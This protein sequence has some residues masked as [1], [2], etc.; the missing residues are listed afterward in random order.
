M[1]IHTCDPHF[2]L[3]VSVRVF[4][5]VWMSDE[6][7]LWIWMTPYYRLMYSLNTKGQRKEIWAQKF[8]S[9]LFWL[10]TEC[11][12]TVYV[13]LSTN[14]SLPLLLPYHDGQNFQMRGW[15]TPFHLWIALV[16]YF[17]KGTRK[18]Y[19]KS[20]KRFVTKLLLIIPL[21]ESVILS[22][23]FQTLVLAL[24]NR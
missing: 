23:L 12:H 10:G 16:R 18:I 9:L 22:L 20:I 7:H 13:P 21:N 15:K 6:D 17:V 2:I 8:I 19:N 3:H 5:E 24:C 14:A 11:S 4:Q 1:T